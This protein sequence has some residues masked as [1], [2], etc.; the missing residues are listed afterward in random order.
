MA[1][2]KRSNYLKIKMLPQNPEKKIGSKSTL[3]TENFLKSLDGKSDNYLDKFS[4]YAKYNTLLQTIKD[5]L[6]LIK[7]QQ[8]KYSNKTF[9]NLIGYSIQELQDTK[10]DRYLSPKFKELVLERYKKRQ[11]GEIVPAEYEIELIKKDG[12][13]ISVLLNVGLVSS[14]N[15]NLEFVIIRDLSEIEFKDKELKRAENEFEIIFN[16]TNVAIALIDTQGNLIRVNEKWQTL[17][18][19]D[20]S[21]K[22]LENVCEIYLP[23][24]KENISDFLSKL[25]NNENQTLRDQ[26]TFLTSHKSSFH[27]DESIAVVKNSNNEVE[28]LVISIID[29]SERVEISNQFEQ[30]R[31]LQQYFMEYIPDSIYFKDTS[32]K[33]IKANKSTLEKMGLESIEELLGKTDFDFF[34]TEHAKDARKD[35]EEIMK[36]GNSVLSKVEKE[37]WSNGRITWASTTKVPLKDD[38]NNIIGT[39]GITRDITQLKKSEDIRDALYKIST[40]VTSVPDIKNLYGFI[41]DI[42]MGLMK[43]DN[44]YIALYD[45]ETNI[46]SFPYFV[47]QIDPPPEP[48]KAGRGLT[49]YILRCGQAKLIDAETDLQLR[50]NGETSLLGEPTQIWLGVPL[51]VEGKTIGVIVVQDYSDLTTYGEEEK[52]ILTYVSEQI[53]LAIDKKYNEQKIIEYSEELKELNAAKDKFFSIVAHDLK[54][55]F[56]G[57][58]GL[59]RMISEEYDS[60]D[61]TELKSSLHIL[62]ESTE[63]IYAL[64]ENLLDWSRIESGKMKFQPT[65]QNMFMIVEDT[66]RLLNQNARVKDITL[67]NK[68]DHNNKVW[69]DLNML[70]SLIQNLISNALKFTPIGGIVEVSENHQD[71]MMQFTVTDTGMGIDKQNIEKLFKI[72]SSYSTIG[73][74]QEKGTGLGLVLCKEIVNI[75]GGKIFIDSEIGSGTKISFTLKKYNT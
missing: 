42:I 18:D 17:F 57:L 2:V 5:G 68:L 39:F 69:G 47:D 38:E 32:S 45:E 41:H 73:T 15:D 6:V 63:H 49:E 22:N 50:A 34:E 40:A 53:A 13:S 58:L 19:Y 14:E 7:D 29:I 16:H 31:K 9:S 51:I 12:N 46:V 75:H 60:M 48:R 25:V 62:K 21:T 52:E 1:I 43:A 23:Q 61:E 64:I 30:E 72:D 24:D 4:F 26:K 67:R 10:I 37:I 11:S 55:P 36:T 28:F 71:D 35:E 56:Q 8:I 59:S 54:S 27:G 65:Y 74:N 70:Q 44:F 20:K 3:A 33:F 66:R